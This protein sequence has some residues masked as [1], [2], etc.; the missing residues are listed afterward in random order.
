MYCLSIHATIND[1]CVKM[2]VSDFSL[3]S[4]CCSEHMWLQAVELKLQLVSTH[5]GLIF[6]PIRA[7]SVDPEAG[8]G[9]GVT[10]AAVL[11]LWCFM[12]LNFISF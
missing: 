4:P 7:L 9:S 6:N 11:L 12:A 5:H 10:A 8:S 2:H 3:C 1:W